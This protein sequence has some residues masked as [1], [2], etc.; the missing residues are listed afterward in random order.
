MIDPTTPTKPTVYG[1]NQRG[2]PPIVNRMAAARNPDFSAIPIAS[3]MV[4]T[5]TNGGNPM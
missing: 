4:A 2:A 1:S 3:R 5:V